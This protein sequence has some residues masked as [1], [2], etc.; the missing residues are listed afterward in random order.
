M[1]ARG[2]GAP[3]PAEAEVVVIGGGFS[4][5]GA[6]IGLL[7]DGVRDV[8]VLERDDE[9][10]GTWWANTYPGCACDIPSNLYSFSFAPNPDWTRTYSR[11]PEIAAYLRRVAGDFGVRDRVR[12]GCT[13]T[14]AEWEDG[15]ARWRVETTRGPIHARVLVAAAGPLAAPRW[16]DVP[17]LDRFA[18]RLFH[19]SGWDHGYDLRGRRVAVVGT[20]AS[21]IQ[22]VPEIAPLVDR[23]HVLQRTPPWVIPHH[24]RDTTALERRLY[25]AVPALQ[26]LARGGIYAGREALVL[27]LA[28]RPELMELLE[29]AVRGHLRRAV[30]DPDL[31][32]RATPSYMLG[33]KRIL[34]SNDWY[35]ALARPNVELVADRLAAVDAD[36][37]ITGGGRRIEVDAIICGTGF[38]VTDMPIAALVRGRAGRTLE[39]VWQGSPRAHLGTTVPGFPNLFILPGPNTGLGHSSLV[40]M[41]ESQVAYVVRALRVMRAH[42]LAALEVRPEAATAWTARLDA[43]SART[44]W[45]TGCSSWYLDAAGRNAVLWPDFT[46][47]FRRRL[48]RFD[49]AE[50]ELRPAVAAPPVAMAA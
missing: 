38:H 9:V 17:G 7:R 18:G 13:A 15:A 47:R 31:R 32:R 48:R 33:C 4:G 30:P 39:E 22:F 5:L 29:R 50:Y 27:G 8:V 21:A 20:G 26:K 42:G 10:G 24:V 35:P 11:Q 12:T 34:P 28:K 16:P 43:R 37:V 1:E 45:M 41:I 46:F 23:L 3:L 49:P 40:Y 44:V 25:R 2:D 19:S 6:A 36:A 14:S